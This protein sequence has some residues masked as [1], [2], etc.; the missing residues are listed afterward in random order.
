MFGRDK[1]LP[2]DDGN[3]PEPGATAV[4]LDG[5]VPLRG[6]DDLKQPGGVGRGP[7]VQSRLVVGGA[8]HALAYH[9]DEDGHLRATGGTGRVPQ[10]GPAVP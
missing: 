1:R 3:P 7:G 6:A 9:P 8:G 2:S 5:A 4:N 10:R